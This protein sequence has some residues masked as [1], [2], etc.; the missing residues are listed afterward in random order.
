[1]NESLRNILLVSWLGVWT[2]CI[3]VVGLAVVL[4]AERL[5]SDRRV[6]AR[7]R[8]LFERENRYSRERL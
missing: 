6:L 4:A 1:M 2:V 8:G 3:I 7:D 5:R